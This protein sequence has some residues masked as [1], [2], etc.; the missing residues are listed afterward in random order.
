MEHHTVFSHLV[1]RNPLTSSAILSIV[2]KNIKTMNSNLWRISALKIQCG[3]SM[4]W[5]QCQYARKGSFLLVENSSFHFLLERKSSTQ[6]HARTVS[7]PV[8]FFKVL[9]L[10]MKVS[11][12]EFPAALR[13]AVHG[14][15]LLRRLQGLLPDK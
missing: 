10:E 1:I 7:C 13:C 3:F 2:P 5:Q 4:P 15:L 11:V 14:V 9:R 12:L 8:S 6:S